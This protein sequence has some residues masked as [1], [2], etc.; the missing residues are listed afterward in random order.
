MSMQPSIAEQASK[1]VERSEEVDVSTYHQAND[2][3][4]EALETPTHAG[5]EQHGRETTR[6]DEHRQSL[7]EHQVAKQ[8][9]HKVSLWKDLPAVA[10]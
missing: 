5:E 8:P 7:S 3:P 9:D 10:I 1:N 4:D 6:I 2:V